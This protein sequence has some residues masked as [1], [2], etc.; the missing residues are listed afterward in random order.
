MI[1]WKKCVIVMYPWR[2][3]ANRGLKWPWQG[4]RISSS[5]SVGLPVMDGMEATRMLKADARTGAI[6]IIALT[7]YVSFEDEERMIAAG[8]DGIL[9]KPFDVRKLL[10]KVCVYLTARQDLQI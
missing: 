5:W 2:L 9:P 10:D 4:C 6:P 3:T 7:G 1:Y 8:F